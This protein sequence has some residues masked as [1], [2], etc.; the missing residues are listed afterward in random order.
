M[1]IIDGI[2]VGFGIYIGRKIAKTLSE[3][4][5]EIYPLLKERLKK[6]YILV[7]TKED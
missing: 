3:V 5:A 2:K 4:L 7:K 1:K 6:G